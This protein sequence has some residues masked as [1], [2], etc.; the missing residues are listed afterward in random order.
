MENYE[1]IWLIRS[2]KVWEICGYFGRKFEYCLE[3]LENMENVRKYRDCCEE[4]K[5]VKIWVI[6][7]NK[8]KL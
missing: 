3:M 6:M 2:L 1:D 7:K 8:E 5:Y 4:G